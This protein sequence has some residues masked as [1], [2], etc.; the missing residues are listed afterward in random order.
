VQFAACVAFMQS[1]PYGTW[2]R[3]NSN[4]FVCRHL[5]SLTTPFRPDVH[6]PHCSPGGGG[7]CID[8]T[9][10]SFFDQEF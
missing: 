6:C 2:D 8:F 4:T 9:Y 7:T 3:A 5:H 1:I 10:D